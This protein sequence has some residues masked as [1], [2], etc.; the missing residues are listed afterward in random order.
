MPVEDAAVAAK[1]REQLTQLLGASGVDEVAPVVLGE[2]TARV[3]V[4]GADAVASA[5]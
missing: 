3:V 4:D 2:L 5:P 1:A